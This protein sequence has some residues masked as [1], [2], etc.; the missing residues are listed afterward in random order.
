MTDQETQT[1]FNKIMATTAK[2]KTLKEKRTTKVNY[3]RLRN[4]TNIL[5]KLCMTYRRELLQL[6]KAMPIKKRVIKI[7]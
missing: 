2:I 1:T 7:K 4:E 3:V 6:K 5:S